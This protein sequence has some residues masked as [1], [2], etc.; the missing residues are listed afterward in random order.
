MPQRFVHEKE[1]PQQI[2]S[3]EKKQV[4]KGVRSSYG[5]V[6]AAQKKTQSRQ[7]GQAHI[8]FQVSLGPKLNK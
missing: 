5:H 2:T 4:S 8:K 3:L 6:V 7:N 1:A